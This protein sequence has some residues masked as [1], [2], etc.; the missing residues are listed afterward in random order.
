MDGLEESGIPRSLPPYNV[1]QGVLGQIIDNQ[2]GTDVTHPKRD[3]Q[4]T[5]IH[6]TTGQYQNAAW[7]QAIDPN[8]LP[9]PR[10]PPP[11]LPP[12]QC[13]VYS[14][15]PCPA[16]RGGSGSRSRSGCRPRSGSWCSACAT[17]TGRPSARRQSLRGAGQE[18]A[19]CTA[20]VLS[21]PHALWEGARC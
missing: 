9:L 7:Q 11:L 13:R 8:G 14:T 1:V 12:P 10:Y 21:S 17:T 5:F 15:P 2:C 16:S 19:A 18:V 20:P 6:L 4:R 3:A